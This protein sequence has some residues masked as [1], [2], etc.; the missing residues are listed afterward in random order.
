MSILVTDTGFHPLSHAGYALIK[1]LEAGTD[2][3]TFDADMLNADLIRIEF[4]S[5][6]D[7]RGFTLARLLRLRGFRG[8]LHAFGHVISDQYA[9]VRR[10]GFDAVE[11]S[12]ALAARQ[13]QQDWLARANWQAHDYQSRLGKSA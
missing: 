9:M 13:S 7:G 3:A 10:S 6:A 8:V 1:T 4:T 11:I 12:D 2:P 5:F